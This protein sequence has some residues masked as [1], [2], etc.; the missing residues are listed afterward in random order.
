[1]CRLQNSLEQ[2][3]A[4][5][6]RLLLLLSITCFHL[7]GVRNKNYESNIISPGLS[8][9]LSYEDFSLLHSVQTDPGAHRVSCPMFIGG[10]F[11]GGIVVVR[12]TGHS[13]PSSVEVKN[14]K[15]K[16]PPS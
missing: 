8:C 11:P 6:V 14:D 7:H 4:H 13:P 12:E 2:D 1:M 15:A 16:S 10:S 9:F 5:C 3:K